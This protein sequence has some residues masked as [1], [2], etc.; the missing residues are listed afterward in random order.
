MKRIYF[1]LPLN[2]LALICLIALFFYGA[3]M[4]SRIM[5]L[6]IVAL[7]FLLYPIIPKKNKKEPPQ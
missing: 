1:T 2:I 3:P 5:G 7:W 6:L 4:W